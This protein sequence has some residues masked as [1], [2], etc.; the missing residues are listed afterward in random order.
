LNSLHAVFKFD[1][2]ILTELQIS[3]SQ[4]GTNSLRTGGVQSQRDKGA[5]KP[6]VFITIKVQFDLCV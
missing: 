4:S 5:E 3:I 2:L 1:V 6:A